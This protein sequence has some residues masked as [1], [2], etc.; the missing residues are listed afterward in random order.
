MYGTEALPSISTVHTTSDSETRSAQKAAWRTEPLPDRGAFLF[1][2]LIWALMTVTGIV[3][4]TRFGPTVLLW[5]DYSLVSRIAGVE[6]VTLSWL[7]SQTYEHRIPLVRL[8]LLEVLRS[9]EADP[10][11]ALVFS[12]GLQSVTAAVLLIVVRRARGSSSYS[13]A[14]VPIILLNLG[15]HGIFLSAICFAGVLALAILGF[16]LAV[17]VRCDRAPSLSTSALAAFLIAL[18]P[19]C[20]GGGLL[21]AA[22][23][24]FWLWYIAVSL[25]RSNRRGSRARSLFALACTVPALC[26]FRLYFQG[27]A[28]PP[29][30][31]LGGP[32]AALRTAAQCV[33]MSLG[34]AGVTLWPWSAIAVLSFLIGAVITLARAWFVEPARRTQIVGLACA[35]GAV[36]LMEMALGWARSGQ[37]EQAGFQNRYTMAAVP[38]LLAAYLAF[39]LY[40]SATTRRLIPMM[41]FCGSCVLLWPNTQDGWEAGHQV[42][43]LSAAFDRDLSSGVPLYRLVRR[44]TPALHPSQE[45]F[46]K[47]IEQL[48][49]AGIGKYRLLRMDGRFQEQAIPLGPQPQSGQGGRRAE[50]HVDIK[51]C[52][53]WC[54]FDLPAPTQVCGIRMRFTLENPDGIPARFRLGWQRPGQ[55]TYPTDQQYSNWH[56]LGG[57]DQVT[58]IWIDD[59]VTRIRIQ[60]DNRPCRFTVSELTLLHSPQAE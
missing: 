21:F 1:V 4:V 48:H 28:S 31:Q 25:G 19:L 17:V 14:F 36:F 52:D 11:A 43:A 59:F 55:E 33:V 39:A 29:H 51:N 27:Y 12:V 32:L 5:D 20:G 6:P 24:I 58:T 60:P 44:Y 47:S 56:F 46:Y 9:S 23:M 18:L 30:G 22:G 16:L 42:H 35:L 15:H 50:F 38:A 41:V 7:W 49:Q 57:K 10:R 37:G 13:D 45:T 3:Y 40:G 2:A 8:I 34:Q 26:L 53:S 54:I